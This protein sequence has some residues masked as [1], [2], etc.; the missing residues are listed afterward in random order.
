MGVHRR[1]RWHERAMARSHVLPATILLATL[2][3]VSLLAA[4]VSIQPTVPASLTGATRATNLVAVR[5]F[6]DAVNDGI[7]AGDAASLAFVLSPDY[8]EADDAGNL[9]PGRDPL[10]Q[11]L[12]ALHQ[13]VPRLTLETTE[14]IGDGE[15]V[16][17]VVRARGELRAT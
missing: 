12:L 17:A 3:G 11:A 6:Y 1:V 4:A 15:R 5:R 16:L 7:A 14:L 8:R 13:T 9:V 2:T 10:E